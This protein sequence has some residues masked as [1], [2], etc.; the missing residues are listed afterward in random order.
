MDGEGGPNAGCA[1]H[2]E[3]DARVVG[4]PLREVETEPAAGRSRAPR[5]LAA[6]EGTTELPEED[7]AGM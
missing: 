7:P 5:G 3:A 2:L 4:Q 6:P 1:A